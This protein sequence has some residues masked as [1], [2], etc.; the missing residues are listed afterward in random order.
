MI[1]ATHLPYSEFRLNV[2]GQ[3]YHKAREALP[4]APAPGQLAAL[5]NYEKMVACPLCGNHGS[6]LTRWRESGPGKDRF[7]ATCKRCAHTTEIALAA[8]APSGT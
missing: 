5:T 6:Y 3:G 1:E 4:S 8:P 7:S 2:E